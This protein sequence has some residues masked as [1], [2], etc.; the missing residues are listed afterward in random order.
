MITHTVTHGGRLIREER[1]ASV[2]E[3]PEATRGY[4]RGL[5]VLAPPQTYPE[6]TPDLRVVITSCASGPA[7]HRVTHVITTE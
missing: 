3:I 5:G 7:A 2:R 4:Y 1:F 6:V